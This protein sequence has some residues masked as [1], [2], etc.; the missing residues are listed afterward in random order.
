MQKWS[1]HMCWRPYVAHILHLITTSLY[2]NTS[3]LFVRI[4]SRRR[5]IYRLNGQ[6]SVCILHLTIL[7]ATKRGCLRTDVINFGTTEKKELLYIIQRNKNNTQNPRLFQA[8]KFFFSLTF[9][10]RVSDSR[11]VSVSLSL[12]LSQFCCCCLSFFMR[13]VRLD[14]MFVYADLKSTFNDTRIFLF[15][16]FKKHFSSVLFTIIRADGY[17]K[18]MCCACEQVRRGH[19]A[20]SW[21][22]E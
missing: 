1:R 16:I 19:M 8:F 15:Y 11:S 12:C 18:K 2:R 9:H 14:W 13:L 20:K 21:D 4:W 6:T 10:I 22:F 7:V 3:T 5:I 17:E